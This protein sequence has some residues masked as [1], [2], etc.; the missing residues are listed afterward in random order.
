MVSMPFTSLTPSRECLVAPG[1]GGSASATLLSW[2]SQAPTNFYYQEVNYFSK[3]YQTF[4][5]FSVYLAKNTNKCPVSPTNEEI[6][7]EYQMECP[8]AEDNRCSQTAKLC[9]VGT[10]LW[11][12][13]MRL[14]SEGNARHKHASFTARRKPHG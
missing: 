8:K 11:V 10:F 12:S 9:S 6:S 7:G 14:H 4:Q 3:I 5:A 2:R 13:M 1:G